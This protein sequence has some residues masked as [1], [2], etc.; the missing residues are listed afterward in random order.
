MVD[1]G[2]SAVHD[3]ARERV[4]TRFQTRMFAFL[5][6]VG[7]GMVHTDMEQNVSDMDERRDHH[8]RT[9]RLY[10]R[11]QDRHFKSTE[12]FRRRA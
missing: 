12:G 2:T 5:N 10:R 4:L 6:I 8:A 11:F 1:T 9:Q 3:P 7:M